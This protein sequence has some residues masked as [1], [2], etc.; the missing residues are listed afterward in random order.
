MYAIRSYYDRQIDTK[1]A[2]A[3]IRRCLDAYASLNVVHSS[4]TLG[5]M[6]IT[7]ERYRSVS[8]PRGD[9]ASIIEGVI[10]SYSIHY[11]KL[12]ESR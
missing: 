10:T 3:V 7:M 9:E 2:E 5:K 4:S 8:R 6:A 12:Y 1:E 11:T